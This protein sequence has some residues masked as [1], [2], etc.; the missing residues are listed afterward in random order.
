MGNN[1]WEMQFKE[2]GHGMQICEF[3]RDGTKWELGMH[4]TTGKYRNMV[5]FYIMYTTQVSLEEADEIVHLYI[6]EGEEHAEIMDFYQAVNKE[7]LM[8]IK[9]GDWPLEIELNI[10]IFDDT[11]D[12][13]YDTR[14]KE[15]ADAGPYGYIDYFEDGDCDPAG[16]YG[17]SSHE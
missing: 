11:P 16:G 4:G 3:E 12:W 8:D 5:L 14:D 10:P 15:A 17:L 13:D 7:D 9:K 6:G 2:S 1:K